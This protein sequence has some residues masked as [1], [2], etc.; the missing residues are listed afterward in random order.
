MVE[1]GMRGQ[2]KKSSFSLDYCIEAASIELSARVSGAS[3][4][5]AVEY[6][7]YEN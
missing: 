4:V 3:T 6:R 5:R 2:E 1:L 7:S